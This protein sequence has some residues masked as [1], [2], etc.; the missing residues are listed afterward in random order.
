MTLLPTLPDKS[1][2][3]TFKKNRHGFEPGTC[4]GCQ[5]YVDKLYR[6]DR[7]GFYYCS[8]CWWQLEDAEQEP[9]K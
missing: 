2:W 7:P 5:Q 3:A 8:D 4:D 1:T 6:R 9:E